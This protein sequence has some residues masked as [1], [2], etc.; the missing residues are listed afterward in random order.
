MVIYFPSIF[1]AIWNIMGG[2]DVDCY[3]ANTWLVNNKRCD[4]VNKNTLGAKKWCS[5]E[6]QWLKGV[7]WECGQD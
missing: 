5:Q 3:L 6:K 4:M 1:P 7:I 2:L